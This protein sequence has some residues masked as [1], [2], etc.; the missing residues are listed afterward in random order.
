MKSVLRSAIRSCR[1]IL[2]R[3][4]LWSTNAASFVKQKEMW[5][6]LAIFCQF[7]KLLKVFGGNLA[8]WPVQ[9]RLSGLHFTQWMVALCVITKIFSYSCAAPVHCEKCRHQPLVYYLFGRLK[10]GGRIADWH[11]TLLWTLVHCAMP[12]AVS[13]ALVMTLFWTQAKHLCFLHAYIWF[14][15][16]D[17]NICLSN[18]SCELLNRKQKMENK[19]IFIKIW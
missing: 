4:E 6:D 9:T 2:E 17:T 13:W 1:I 18:L 10:W 12:W 16:F 15:W 11:H 7:V 19:F 14:I 8:L 3:H 5:P